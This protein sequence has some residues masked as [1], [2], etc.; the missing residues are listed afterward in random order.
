MNAILVFAA[1]LLLPEIG[2]EFAA[3]TGLGQ[4]FAGSVF[5][6][7]S[8]LFGSNLFNL[9]ILAVV[10]LCYISGPIF[11]DVAKGHMLATLATI[12]MSSIAILGITYRA[13]RKMLWLSWDAMAIA[14]IFVINLMLLYMQ[15]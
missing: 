5:I 11:A 15:H 3:T 14:F 9:F 12:A 6:A 10:D 4:T 8:N 1:A 2:V 13:E 7:I